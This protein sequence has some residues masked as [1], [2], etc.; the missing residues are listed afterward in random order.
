MKELHRLSVSEL[1]YI[2][3]NN[4]FLGKDAEFVS[5]SLKIGFPPH[6]NFP[7]AGFVVFH[8]CVGTYKDPANARNGLI[9]RNKSRFVCNK[10]I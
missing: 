9:S 8:C 4:K 1:V 6:V 2:M 5:N 3:C 10:Y 7:V